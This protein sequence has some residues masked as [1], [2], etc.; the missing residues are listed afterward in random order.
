VSTSSDRANRQN[1]LTL[2]GALLASLAVVAVI[3]LVTVRPDIAKE[4]RIDWSTI[5]DST[6]KSA[7]LTNPVFT[8]AD[9]D[10]WAN[11]VEYTEGTYPE[12]YIGFV[13]PSEGFVSVEQYLNELPPE[14]LT[15][16]DSVP[17]ST[18]VVD[19]VDWDVYD[20]SGLDDPG[21]RAI[22]YVRELTSGS[23][24]VISGTA[25]VSEIELVASR[26]FTSLE[27]GVQ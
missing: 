16:M 10:W 12:W 20:R 2:T 11:R 23:T 24:L 25:S 1:A 17:P 13:S 15:D 18:K 8:E 22:I 14:I 7:M 19:D 27:G 5:H 26:A 21:N 3:V 6:P 4:N 9:G